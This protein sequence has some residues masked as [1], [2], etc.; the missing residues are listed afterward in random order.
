MSNVYG[1][2]C[3]VDDQRLEYSVVS[4]TYIPNKEIS[5]EAIC[6]NPYSRQENTFRYATSN[7][8]GTDK[9]LDIAYSIIHSVMQD[10]GLDHT[11]IHKLRI[12]NQQVFFIRT[13]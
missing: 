1:G 4:L 7:L 11:K 8:F 10:L 3:V 12:H 13:L 9:R 2:T 5:I 6:L